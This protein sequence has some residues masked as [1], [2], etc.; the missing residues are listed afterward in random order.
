MMFQDSLLLPPFYVNWDVL[1]QA[2]RDEN[3]AVTA[4]VTPRERLHDKMKDERKMRSENKR[5]PYTHERLQNIF[6]RKWSTICFHS[7]HLCIINLSIENRDKPVC[8][9]NSLNFNQNEEISKQSSNWD[10]LFSF[11]FI[12]SSYWSMWKISPN[13]DITGSNLGMWMCVWKGRQIDEQ[14]H[15]S[16]IV[17]CPMMSADRCFFI[18]VVPAWF[19]CATWSA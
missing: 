11:A 19:A 6:A 18:N 12:H 9:L 7:I 15:Q 3:T 2:T 8:I 10:I 5:S 14:Y 13:R 1:E 17:K 16:A 4:T